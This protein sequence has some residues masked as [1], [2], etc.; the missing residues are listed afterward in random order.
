MK[1]DTAAALFFSVLCLGA[2]PVMGA[3]ATAPFRVFDTGELTPDRY[4]VIERLWTGTWR[5]SFRVPRHADAGS[6]IAA[7]TSN[8]ASLGA[9]GVVNLHCLND[10]GG[11]GGGYYC[12]GLA[13]KLK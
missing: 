2:A 1:P 12:Y 10:T 9:D 7:L 4:T 3:D 13:I 5:A 6:A 11:W 8:A